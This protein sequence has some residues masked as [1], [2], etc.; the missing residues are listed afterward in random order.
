LQLKLSPVTAA[1]VGVPAGDS[2]AG[3]LA[4]CGTRAAPTC[5]SAQRACWDNG[6]AASPSRGD[7]GIEGCAGEMTSS[8]IANIGDDDWITYESELNRFV[9]RF[10]QVLLCLYDL[11]DFSV[12]CSLT[13]CG[14]IRRSCGGRRSWRT[15]TTLALMSSSP[16]DGDRSQRRCAGAAWTTPPLPRPA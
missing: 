3:D 14:H 11:N 13:S 7:H 4:M 6:G 16:P 15:S 10:P 12:S 9:P 1:M 5:L 8:I 2:V